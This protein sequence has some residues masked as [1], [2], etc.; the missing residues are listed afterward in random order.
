MCLFGTQWFI[1]AFKNISFFFADGNGLIFIHTHSWIH[2][3]IVYIFNMYSHRIY[4]VLCTPSKWLIRKITMFTNKFGE[5][6]TASAM[7]MASIFCD[8]FILII[9]I[10]QILSLSYFPSPHDRRHIN[11][12][13]DWFSSI[14][15]FLNFCWKMPLNIKLNIPS[16]KKIIS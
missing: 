8:A 15:N 4:A 1:Y 5:T 7:G 10:Y 13:L 12:F 14:W 16:G 9:R 6:T 2:I 11:W 3:T